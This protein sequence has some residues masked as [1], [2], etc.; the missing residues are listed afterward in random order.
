MSNTTKTSIE[1]AEDLVWDY[2]KG[3]SF[4]PSNFFDHIKKMYHEEIQT[5]YQDGKDFA[6]INQCAEESTAAAAI[7]HNKLMQE[8]LALLMTKWTPKNKQDNNTK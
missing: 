5:A 3:L 4:V 2:C 1:L 6:L 7:E 8:G